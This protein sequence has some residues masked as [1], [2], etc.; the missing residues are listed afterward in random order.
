MLYHSYISLVIQYVTMIFGLDVTLIRGLALSMKPYGSPKSASPVIWQHR[1]QSSLPVQVQFAKKIWTQPSFPQTLQ[2]PQTGQPQT[3]STGQ[4]HAVTR[5]LRLGTGHQ[6]R[7]PLLR[8]VQGIGE[9]LHVF[10]QLL[11]EKRRE[12]WGVSVG[13]RPGLGVFFFIFHV[14]FGGE[15]S[16]NILFFQAGCW[17]CWFVYMLSDFGVGSANR[18]N[19]PDLTQWPSLP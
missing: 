9:V 18:F 14:F 8:E 4:P 10:C 6:T 17:F 5:S 7:L 2:Q 16:D 1:H 13:K 19:S 12:G 3:G 15:G 11:R